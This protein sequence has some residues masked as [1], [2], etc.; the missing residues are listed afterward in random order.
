MKH[1]LVI[2]IDAF[3]YDYLSKKYT[4]FIHSLSKKYSY[5]P[6]H[7]I[8]GYSDSIRATIFTG[9]YP[10]DH[11]Y[12]MMYKYSPE[13]SPFRGFRPLSITD[14]FPDSFFKRGFRFFL[15]SI[16]CRNL[17]KNNGYSELNTHNIP[18][19]VL[20]CFDYTLKK[21]MLSPGVFNDYPTI[22]DIMQ[23]NNIKYVYIDSSKYG[24]RNYFASSSNVRG[25]LI[26]S[27]ERLDKDIGLIFL[28]LHHL[29]HSAH[30]NGT[31]S[32]RFLRE[33]RNMDRTVEAIS[34]K[35]KKNFNDLDIL[36]FSD[37]G[38]ADATNFVD[39]SFLVKDRGFGKD[40]LVSLDST[41]VRIWYFNHSKKEEIRNT[42]NR[43]KYGRFLSEEDKKKLKINFANR[44]YGDDIYLIDPPYNIFPN[45]VSWL[46][47]YAMHAYHPN[48]ESQAGMFIIM[49]NETTNIKEVKL[50]DI[51]PTLL[52]RLDFNPPKN[53]MGISI[54]G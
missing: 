21:S 14:R 42:L 46:K 43:S 5:L 45:F 8:L 22:F 10:E 11:N 26:D 25:N 50:I 44:Y 17:A 31:S 27:I 36:I 20:G 18:F 6:L 38:M 29:D 39:L 41:M 30:R 16:L 1:L 35:A 7:P 33:L 54:T 19:N 13:T 12:W 23:Q 52:N 32:P 53:C 15:S 48:E 4:P 2:L 47:P 34:E 40:Y 51:M 37:H 9:A 3:R 49:E 24:W 28:Y